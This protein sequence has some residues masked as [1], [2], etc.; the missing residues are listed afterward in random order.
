MV[1]LTQ[2]DQYRFHDHPKGYGSHD[3]GLGPDRSGAFLVP[4]LLD[5]QPLRCIAT[6]GA[7]WDHVSVSRVDRC[8]TWEEMDQLHRLFFKP[9]EV[10]MQLHL[11][12]SD[13]INYYPFCLHLWRPRSRARRIP[14]PPKWMV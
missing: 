2:L 1:P 8:P 10:A 14:L 5:R 6:V 3:D 9:D 11:P 7:G 12:A 13:H 4:S